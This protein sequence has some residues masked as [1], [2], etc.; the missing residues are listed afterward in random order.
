VAALAT[1][2]IVPVA[3]VAAPAIAAPAVETPMAY[4]FRRYVEARAEIDAIDDLD[5]RGVDTGTRWDEA[6][7]RARN[8]R[9]SI[10]RTPA[11]SENDLWLKVSAILLSGGLPGL[12]DEIEGTIKGGNTYTCTMALSVI[13]DLVALRSKLV[14]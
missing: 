10:C 3:A 8:I 13:A 1:T 11:K 5:D 14:F 2:T 4:A 6:V 7:D 12:H 9:S